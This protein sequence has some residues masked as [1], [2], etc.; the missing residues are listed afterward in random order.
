MAIRLGKMKINRLW[1][2]VAMALVLGLLATWLSVTYLRNREAA[3]TSELTE[4]ARGGQTL[5]VIVPTSDLPAGTVLSESVLAG[6]PIAVDMV[7][8]DTLLADQA[9][10]VI[11]KP[12]LTAVQRGRPLT[13]SQVFDDRPK[14]FSNMLVKGMRAITIDIDELN[15]I[16]QMLKPGDFVDLH[17]ITADTTGSSAGT[18]AGQQIFPF[19]QRVKVLATGLRTRD[20]LAGTPRGGID[21][22]AY[23]T[24]TVE[25]TPQEAA[26][27]ALAQN[28]GRIRTTLRS[29]QD[30]A[31]STFGQVTTTQLVGGQLKAPAG[32]GAN[33]GRPA[34]P[35]RVEYIVGGRGGEGASAPITVNVPGLQALAAAQGG[36]PGAPAAGANVGSANTGPMSSQVAPTINN[37]VAQALG[38]AR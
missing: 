13:R 8:A 22:G 18:Q 15:S 27:I 34:T 32:R 38:A 5:T 37:A 2:L 26:A 21:T 20:G 36:A 7:Y 28:T 9:E 10:L 14:E 16:S 17:L 19:L 35:V 31:L 29:P 6:R 3:I 25:A 1:M 30:T 12:L 23:S 11:G 4:R 24:V 33:G